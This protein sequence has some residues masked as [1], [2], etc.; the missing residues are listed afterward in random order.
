MQSVGIIGC[1]WLGLPLGKKLVDAGY[2]VIGSTTTPE[3]LKEIEEAGIDPVLLSFNPMPEGQ[4]FNKLFKAETLFVN[5]PPRSRSNP[6]E[7]YR[8][9]I[10]YIKYQLQNSSVKRVIFISSTSFYPNTGDVVTE[11][12]T[13]DLANGSTKAVVWGELEISQIK[14]QLSILR[15]GG[16]MG[17]NRIPGKWFAGKETTGAET[18]VNYIHQE[19]VIE[20]V[21]WLLENGTWPT[22]KNMVSDQHPTRKQVH[23]AMAAKYDFAPPVW[24][25]PQVLTSK[26]VESNVPTS[27]NFKSPLDY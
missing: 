1:G 5:I 2:R 15:C 14:Q 25:D 19:D 22:I 23:E 8:E 11:K 21:L 3:K 16:L 9:Q 13:Y 4:N 17:E 6:P 26:I 7:F 27:L 18:P 20:Y 10:K 12:T 24:I